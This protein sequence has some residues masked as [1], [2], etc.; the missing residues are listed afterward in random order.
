VTYNDAYGAHAL[1]N[2]INNLIPM[3]A[4]EFAML[5]VLARR[6]QVPVAAS[7]SAVVLD[8]LCDLAAAL[9]MLGLAIRTMPNP[10][11]AVVDGMEIVATVLCLGM[12]MLALA[13]RLRPQALKI[14]A[15][16]IPRRWHG[17]LLHRIDALLLGLGVLGR[18]AVLVKAVLL[19]AAVWS[20]AALSFAA[21]I[22]AVQP[23]ATFAMGAFTAGT[24]AMAFLVP[25]A[26]GGIGVFHAAVV[27]ALSFF[28]VPAETAL[29]FALITHALTFAVGLVVAGTWTLIN[30]LDPRELA[31]ASAARDAA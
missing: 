13:V 16:L 20:L 19:S 15:A 7:L 10:P 28:G 21:G 17:A 4:G 3:R 5:W 11:Q 29:A 31:R 25:A 14:A 18:P 8:R 12:G 2:A 24:I 22:D 30:G 23:G 1:G 6:A 26:P 9:A 27:F